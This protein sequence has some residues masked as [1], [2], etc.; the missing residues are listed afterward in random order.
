MRVAA[1]VHGMPSTT[2][3]PKLPKTRRYHWYAVLL[4]I[5][6]TLFPPLGTSSLTS[7]PSSTHNHHHHRSRRSQIRHRKG[8]LAQ[9]APDNRRLYPWS[10]LA[11]PISFRVSIL[12]SQVTHTTSTYRY[13]H[14]AID[15]S[16]AFLTCSRQQ[17]IRNNKTHQR[18]PKWAVR[19]GLV[20][21]STIKRHGRRSQWAGK[22]ND[23]NL[24]TGY[25]QQP[26][27][28]GQVGPS[29][30]PTHDSADNPPSNRHGLWRPDDESY[31]SAEREGSLQAP[32]SDGRW[33]YLPNLN[34]SLPGGETT[35]KKKKKKDRW[36]RTEDAYTAS[37]QKKKKKKSKNRSAVGDATDVDSTYS[38]RPEST[39]EL[40][41]P[42]DATGGAYGGH[43]QGHSQVGEGNGHA[44]V[45][46]R[47]EELDH[48]F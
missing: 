42:E 4:F 41:L 5:M 39:A 44:V 24:D 32:G 3:T 30:T 1:V 7:P 20:S 6:G 2:T 23:R 17:N 29:R 36:A 12:F 8:F 10:V 38:H 15:T 31:Y 33:R 18:T 43:K 22:Y 21:D 9:P 14:T 19:Y 25:D 45:A 26:L 37:G 27:E 46:S 13:A 11:V 34:E 35:T 47:E 28:D 40:E 16:P 48:E